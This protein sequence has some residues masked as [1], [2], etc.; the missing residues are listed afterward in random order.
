MKVFYR[1]AVIF[2]IVLLLVIAGFDYLSMKEPFWKTI[3]EL[4]DSYEL[5]RVNSGPDEIIPYVE[6]VRAEDGTTQLIIGDSLCHQM[7]TDLQEYNPEISIVG[8]NGAI[9]MAGQYILASEYI[10]NHPDATDIHLF[11]LPE[12]LVRTF[13]A[14]LGYQYV[15]MPF[16][17]TDT[18][19]LLDANTIDAINDFYG[20]FF[21]QRRVVHMIHESP[22]NLKL[23]LNLLRDSGREYYGGGY[24]ELAD[25]YLIKLHKLCQENGITLHLYA[26]PVCEGRKSLV[27]EVE[28]E[29]R[30]TELAE[31]FPDYFDQIYYFPEEQ[32]DDGVHFGEDYDNQEFFDEV[33]RM[34]LA[35]TDLE[36]VL[37]YE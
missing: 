27:D 19:K 22:M 10:R 2:S 31:Y 33:L 34:I 35:G 1:N 23:Y 24:L 37:H 28:Q 15:V 4:T 7:F 12:S 11:V 20:E 6:K 16:A 14:A 5:V 17:E 9:T 18:L 36:K 29:Y 30:N 8:S 32:T 3:A 13:D 21:V 26:A 25:Q